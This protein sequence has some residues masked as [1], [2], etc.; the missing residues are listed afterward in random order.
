LDVRD[1]VSHRF[2]LEQAIQ[3]IATAAEPREETLK[4]VVEKTAGAVGK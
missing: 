4:V 3:A 2:P 1:L